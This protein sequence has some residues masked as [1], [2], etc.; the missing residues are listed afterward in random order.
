MRV[1]S[2]R[3]VFISSH[4][5]DDVAAEQLDKDVPIITTGHAAAHD[6]QNGSPQQDGFRVLNALPGAAAKMM[7]TA[8]MDAL[9]GLFLALASPPC[10]SSSAPAG[11]LVGSLRLPWHGALSMAQRP[12]SRVESDTSQPPPG[13]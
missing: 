1:I 2:L 12:D 3:A 9:G 8:G 7:S 11:D 10:S 4:F 6:G 5:F 13:D